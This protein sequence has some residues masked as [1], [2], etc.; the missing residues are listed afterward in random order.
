MAREGGGRGRA[1]SDMRGAGAAAHRPHYHFLYSALLRPK[2]SRD[3]P[4]Q[5]PTSVTEILQVPSKSFFP[6]R[7]VRVQETVTKPFRG[8]AMSVSI[9]VTLPR[10]TRVTSTSLLRNRKLAKALN[11]RSGFPDCFDFRGFPSFS[12]SRN[13]TFYYFLSFSLCQP[14][15]HTAPLPPACQ[16]RPSLRRKGIGWGPQSPK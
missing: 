14:S 10:P 15:L 4:P 11:S 3:W 13:E 7:D 12:P 1:V 5:L 6:F 8:P 9:P 16:H 2:V